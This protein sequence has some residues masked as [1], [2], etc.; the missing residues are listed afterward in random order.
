MESL[1][2]RSI[3]MV[4]ATA[5]V[6]VPWELDKPYAQP[7]YSWSAAAGTSKGMW[8]AHNPSGHDDVKPSAVKSIMLH[9]WNIDFMLPFPDSR[10]RIAI[11]H[12][13][14]QV[15]RQN[16]STAT[17][18]FLS[19]CLHSDLRLITSDPWVQGAFHITDTDG[20][21]WQ[22]GH[23]GTTTLIDRRLPI[24]SCFRVHY[25]QTRME[26]DALFVDI[27]TGNQGKL[28]RL[29]NTHLES[30]ALEPPFRPLQMQLCA[31]YMHDST[32]DGAVLAGDLNAIQDFDRRLHS[33][34]DLKDAYL[35][36]GGTED[37][38]EAGHTWGQQAATAQRQKFGTSRMD[39]VFFCGDVMCTAF[40]RFGA[41]IELQDEGEREEILKL[42]FDRPWIT[43]HL[44][45]RSEFSLR[46]S[47]MH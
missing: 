37:D 25:E 14:D 4:R 1:V 46:E 20:S 31:Q 6:T 41:G 39:K 7:Y 30:L 13:E 12:L 8:Q 32:V 44:G 26:R 16:A 9:S 2:R 42:G 18:I 5:R 34:N 23:Y 35:E 47:L 33:D 19:E 38:A 40:E 36:L 17:V 24:E 43:D 45:V 10:M 3:E 21:Y 15:S 28:I 27:R 29:C 22:S 11:R